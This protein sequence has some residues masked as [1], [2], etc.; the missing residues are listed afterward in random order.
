VTTVTDAVIREAIPAAWHLRP[1]ELTA[2]GQH[3]L[4]YARI[5]EAHRSLPRI[6]ELL[7]DPWAYCAVLER[8]AVVDPWLFHPL[9]LHYTLTTAPVLRFGNPQRTSGLLDALESLSVTGCAAMT[10]AAR[11]NSHLELRTTATYDPARG[12]FVLHT[13]DAAAVKKPVM[14]AHA[15][16][17]KLAAVYARLVVG[18]ADCGV[19][20][21]AVPL[22]GAD[23]RAVPG[24]RIEPLVENSLLTADFSTVAFDHVRL[25]AESWLDDGARI[26]DGVF[27]DP[28]GDVA[29]RLR[30]T[31]SI[32]PGVWRGIGAMAAAVSRSAAV[33][34]LRYSMQHTTTGRLA[35]E[36]PLIGYRT[37]RNAVFTALA[38]AWAATVAAEHAKGP[39]D[40]TG[41]GDSARTDGSAD[42]VGTGDSAD[43]DSSGGADGSAAGATWAP[44]SSVDQELAL[45]KVI[46][47]E[48]ADRVLDRCRRHCGSSGTLETDHLNRY[49]GLIQGY[50]TAGGD[51]QL[52]LL[53][54]GRA[55][56]EAPERSPLR[57]PA[58]ISPAEAGLALES[59]RELARVA[60]SLLQRRLRGRVADALRRG[61]DRFTAW[62]RELEL[63]LD[64]ATAACDRLLLDLAAAALGRAAGPDAPSD[65]LFGED[66][67]TVLGALATVFALDWA[68]RRC[69]LLS[70]LGLLSPGELGRIRAAREACCDR[71]LPHAERLA[72][73]Y[74]PPAGLLIS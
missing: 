38:T 60:E 72:E 32:G 34:A 69:G 23:G 30:R 7:A 4:T 29:A 10:E 41:T 31:M 20:V 74:G 56:A 42:T 15:G 63:T 58:G 13:P 21:F 9:L 67:Q 12:G 11:S 17:G 16:G 49:R 36:L 55:L 46:T 50:V 47:T 14:A 8:A 2:S 54:T 51:N 3:R 66:T 27:Q 18:G 25:P 6:S 28:A 26:E 48:L 37:Q 45:L 35:P 65:A 73:A 40:R 39:R 70:D 52:I 61:E 24:V 64:T 33:M 57:T 43:A 68:E 44:W 5:R 59:C 19:F 1:A 71:L 22:R 62:N 53:D